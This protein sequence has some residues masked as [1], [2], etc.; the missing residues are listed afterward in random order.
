MA[1]KNPEH[2]LLAQ[3]SDVNRTISGN[4]PRTIPT[5]DCE[6]HVFCDVLKGSSQL[7]DFADHV[8]T[9]FDQENRGVP[10]ELFSEMANLNYPFSTS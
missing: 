6:R 9:L 4:N 8:L 5:L 3:K 10:G 1:A 7:W 2:A